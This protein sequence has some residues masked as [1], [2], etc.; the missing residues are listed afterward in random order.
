MIIES[1]QTMKLLYTTIFLLCLP[2]MSQAQNAIITIGR[3][4]N[5]FGRG[6]CSITTENT[7]SY[8]ASFIHNSDG[9]TVLRIYR[10]KLSKE[11]ED[12]VLGE[13]ITYSNKSSLQFELVETIFFSQ[14]IKECTS[15][16]K[17]KQ[18]DSLSAKI[19]A[20]KITS[21]FID[22]TIIDK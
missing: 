11:D 17:L 10:D 20:T 6:A 9:T 2:L 22:I 4:T 1:T 3:G 8:N 21:Q 7:K 18:L 16:I 5:C 12:R 13:P 14:N 15:S 19:Y